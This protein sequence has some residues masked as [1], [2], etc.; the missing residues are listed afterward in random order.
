MTY[1]APFAP[2]YAPHYAPPYA[3]QYAPQ[4]MMPYTGG[5]AEDEAA[6]KKA[7]ED[8]AKAT[9]PGITDKAWW[10]ETTFSIPRWALATGAVAL[11][12]IGYGWNAGWFDGKAGAK[13][14]TAHARRDPGRHKKSS[15]K[16]GRGRAHH[17]L[18]HRYD[19]D[20]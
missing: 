14:T 6:K 20:F 11:G 10:Q 16:R 8:A 2:A 1:A 15:H 9:K 12:T 17:A 13:R 5:A 7:A 18:G 3:P 19:F 4:A